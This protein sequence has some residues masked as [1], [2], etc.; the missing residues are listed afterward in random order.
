MTPEWPLICADRLGPAAEVLG[1]ERLRRGVEVQAVLRPGKAVALVGVDD[2]LH[3]LARLAHRRDDLLA[4]GLL[5]AR[6][7]RALADQQRRLDPVGLEQR[8]ARLQELLVLL[9]V[10]DALGEQRH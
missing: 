6:I 2:V 5:D 10:A 8:R 4:L 1:Q 3:R 9:Q 7:V